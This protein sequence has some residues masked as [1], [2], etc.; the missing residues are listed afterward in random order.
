[1]KFIHLIWAMR[2]LRLCC[3]HEKLTS[4]RDVFK[5]QK[6]CV[7]DAGVFNQDE[8]R[9]SRKSKEMVMIRM[10]KNSAE[11]KGWNVR[12]FFVKERIKS[13]SIMKKKGK[14]KEV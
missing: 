10:G 6:S 11:L 12:F 7:R 3:V 14:K 4:N 13:Q 1:M 5:L 9:A 2:F 8:R